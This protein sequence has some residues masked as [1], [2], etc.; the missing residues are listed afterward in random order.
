VQSSSSLIRDILSCSLSKPQFFTQSNP[1]NNLNITSSIVPPLLQRQN[2]A[3]TSQQPPQSHQNQTQSQNQFNDFFKPNNVN[4]QP[5][6]VASGGAAITSSPGPPD[7][8][9]KYSLPMSTIA[10]Q[11]SI[12]PA[13]PPTMSQPSSTFNKQH[14]QALLIQPP[15]H[16]MRKQSAPTISSTLL[17]SQAPAIITQSQTQYQAVQHGSPSR[18][19]D[20]NLFDKVPTNLDVTQLPPLKG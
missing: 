8:Q 6:T 17:S 2:S 1:L 4:K 9:R 19:R 18:A 16:M 14:Q 15:H 10:S 7:L 5:T 20:R 13:I 3:P 12:A 11:S